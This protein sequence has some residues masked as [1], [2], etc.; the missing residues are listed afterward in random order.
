MTKLTRTLAL[1]GMLAV[2]AGT[3]SVAP[4]QDKAKK[5][6]KKTGGT[7]KVKHSDKTDKFYVSVYDADDKYVGGG[8]PGYDTKDDVVKGIEALKAA[9]DGAKLEYLKKG[10]DK[11]D[12]KDEKKEKKEPKKEKGEKGEKG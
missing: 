9:L 10:D 4:A 5:S 6:A 12:D 11:D 2:A 3:F 7:I 1:T 8:R